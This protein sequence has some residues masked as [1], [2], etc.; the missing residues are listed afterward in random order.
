MNLLG[1]N[2]TVPTTR[3][4]YPN[5]NDVNTTLLGMNGTP[6]A[7]VP[8]LAPAPPLSDKQRPVGAPVH[9]RS[10]HSSSNVSPFIPKKYPHPPPVLPRKRKNPETR[11]NE[12]G[13]TVSDSQ[14]SAPVPSLNRDRNDDADVIDLTSD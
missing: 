13:V 1:M 6:V 14:A 10:R 7:P 2:G 11:A 12:L 3:T 9:G 8:A 5:L 4:G